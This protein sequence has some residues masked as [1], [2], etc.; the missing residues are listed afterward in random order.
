M[1]CYDNIVVYNQFQCIISPS[2][3]GII[4]I[5]FKTVVEIKKI[6]NFLINCTYLHQSRPNEFS[7]AHSS[8]FLKCSISS[9]DAPNMMKPFSYTL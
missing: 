9:D 5:L 6:C 4:S 7:I 3:T 2:E 8:S 1:Y